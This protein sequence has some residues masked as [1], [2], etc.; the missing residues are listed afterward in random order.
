MKAGV[1]T[2]VTRRLRGGYAGKP[3]SYASYAETF[4]RAHE[5]FSS[6]TFI[7]GQVE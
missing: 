7:Y 3:R 6:Y 1:V 2:R 5:R 4:T